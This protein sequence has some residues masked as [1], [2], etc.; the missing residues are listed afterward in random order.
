VEKR[1]N[2]YLAELAR[3]INM[4]HLIYDTDFILGGY[5]APYLTEQDIQTLHAS[6]NE[7]TPFQEEPDFIQISKMPKHN[8]SIGAALSYIQEFLNIHSSQAQ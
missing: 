4:L 3:A 8:I 6:I 2:S 5:I 7:M 1:W